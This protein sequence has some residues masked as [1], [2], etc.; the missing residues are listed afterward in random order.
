MNWWTS[1]GELMAI[2]VARDQAASV[3]VAVAAWG[4]GSSA[5]DRLGDIGA[6]P[7][8]PRASSFRRR[9]T[10]ARRRIAE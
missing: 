9:V 3:A 8:T 6:I 2:M 4:A 5:A 7:V 10:D 1:L